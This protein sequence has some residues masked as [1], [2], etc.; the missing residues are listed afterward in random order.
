MTNFEWRK[1][2][3]MFHNMIKD[4]LIYLN[5]DE[6]KDEMKK[7]Q[8]QQSEDHNQSVDTVVGVIESEH[9]GFVRCSH[10]LYFGDPR[11]RDGA[12]WHLVD[13]HYDGISI[14]MTVLLYATDAS[15]PR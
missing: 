11:P 8:S 13:S 3:I 6:F 1:S 14:A 2:L 15:I 10:H 4:L 12:T 9:L 5:F 7:I